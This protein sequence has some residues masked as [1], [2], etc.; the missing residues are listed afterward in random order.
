MAHKQ[1][2]DAKTE[3]M[4]GNLLRAG[5]LI[6]AAV[7]LM[8]AFLYFAH[9]HNAKPAYH[10]FRGEPQELRSIVAIAYA[11][12]ALDARAVIQLGLLILIATPVARVVFAI[13]A[14]ALERDRMYV[15]VSTIVL[16]VLI[17]SLVRA[18]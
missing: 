11:A 16:A 15:V 1:W 6:A 18:G 14:F 17:Y 5:V 8:G 3:L 10:I 12:A 7:V 2:S 13:I 4:M 9:P